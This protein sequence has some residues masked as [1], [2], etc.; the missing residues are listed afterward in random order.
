MRSRDRRLARLAARSANTATE[1]EERSVALEARAAII[2]TIRLSLTELGIDP[3]TVAAFRRIDM[4]TDDPA[5][6]SPAP[7]PDDDS[8]FGPE[9]ERLARYYLNHP[10]IDFGQASLVEILAWCI[11]RHNEP[12][13][14]QQETA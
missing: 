12:R 11:A 9:V 14:T 13:T 8:P 3:A 5:P 7:Q 2:D 1:A 4:A 10:A 6:A